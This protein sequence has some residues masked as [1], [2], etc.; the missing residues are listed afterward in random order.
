MLAALRAEVFKTT[1][2]RMSYILLGAVVALI[3]LYYVLLWLQI[4][5]GPGHR[6]RSLVHWLALKDGMSFSN[7]VP[8]ALE[9]ERFFVTLVCVI[10]VA[11]MMG[12]EYDWRTAGQVVSRGVKRH[13]FIAA[14]VA[15]GVAFT[16]VAVVVGFGVALALSAWFSH[17]YAL[18]FG[19]M[20]LER[21]SNAA[22]GLGRTLYVVLPFVAMS[23]AFA[24]FSR[25]AG[26]AV[27]F[28]VGFFF[29]ESIFTGVLNDAQGLLSHLPAALFNAN[30]FAIMQANGTVPAGSL[31]GPFSLTVVSSSV[32]IWRGALI[33][34]FWSATLLGVAFWRFAR[35][36][37]RE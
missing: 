4:Q 14:K 9:L 32:P 3:G 27:G 12:N 33:L 17:V 7:A 22:A 29:L 11:S 1:R 35:R 25:S 8:Y 5:A 13:H 21:G 37:L 2:R 31:T 15:V 20:D 6:R 36:D 28:S 30:I 19:P 23:L 16:A 24:T 10:F 26:Q 18:P 34:L